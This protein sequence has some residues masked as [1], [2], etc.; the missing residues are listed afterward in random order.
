MALEAS[1][2]RFA[3]DLKEKYKVSDV[4][5]YVFGTTYPDTRIP[6]RTPREKTHPPDF[7]EW[8]I[9]EMSDF[10][11]GWYTHLLCDKIQSAIFKEKFPYIFENEKVSQGNEPWVAITAIKTLQDMEDIKMV[12]LSSFW[13][14]LTLA[15][16]PNCENLDIIKKFYQRNADFY[17]HPENI[18]LVDYYHKLSD[19]GVDAS[20]AHK[21]LDKSEEY[22]KNPEMMES[23]KTIYNSMIAEALNV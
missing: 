14:D 6:T 2:I 9:L 7:Y 5:K 4:Q 10:K 20:I 17:K 13:K 1:H 3:L 23:I 19:L 12:D 8:P 21:V 18:K 11:K 16:N 22:S 15:E